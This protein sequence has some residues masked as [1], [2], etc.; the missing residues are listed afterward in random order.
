MMMLIN[1]PMKDD[2]RVYIHPLSFLMCSFTGCHP[3][4]YMTMV[5]LKYA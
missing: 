1:N 3:E 5:N 2:D 4:D